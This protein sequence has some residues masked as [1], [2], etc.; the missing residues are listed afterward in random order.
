MITSGSHLK[1]AKALSKVAAKNNAA[2]IVLRDLESLTQLFREEKMKKTLKKIAYLEKSALAKLL[3]NV[4]AGR[5]S[6]VTMNLLV[7]LSGNRKLGLLPKISEAYAR[8]Y[9]DEKG[10]REVT[11]CSARKLS[12]EEELSV[13]E[14]L[15]VKY[16]RPVSARFAANADLIGGLQIYERGYLTDCSV[17]GYLEILEKTLMETEI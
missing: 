2:E 9:H 10:I 16:D 12:S 7:L 15:Q 17:K 6:P 1:Y 14:K 11:V 13:I 8:T 3:Q 4:F 5:V